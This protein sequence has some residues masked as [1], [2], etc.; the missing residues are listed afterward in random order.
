MRE[1]QKRKSVTKKDKMKKLKSVK[2]GY[3]NFKKKTPRSQEKISFG[4]HLRKKI[5]EYANV[6]NEPIKAWKWVN[7][8]R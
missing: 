6:W 3:E 1:L 4:N 8:N 2:K 5:N 7:K